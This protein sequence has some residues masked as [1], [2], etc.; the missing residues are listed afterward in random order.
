MRQ[1]KQTK[2]NE[3]TFHISQEMVLR[4]VI[5]IQN[6]NLIRKKKQGEPVEE[7]REKRRGSTKILADMR[8][9]VLD[10]TQPQ[11][12][13]ASVLAKIPSLVLRCVQQV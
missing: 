6:V 2:I 1:K 11:W 13:E 3:Q 12:W 10:I 7:R 4:I 5:G 8:S 9:K